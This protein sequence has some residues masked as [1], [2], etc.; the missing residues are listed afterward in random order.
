MVALTDFVEVDEVG[1]GLLGPNPRRLIELSREDAHGSRNRD[2]LDVAHE[3][4]LSPD[5][6]GFGLVT[7]QR[8]IVSSARRACR[9]LTVKPTPQGSRHK[10]RQTMGPLKGCSGLVPLIAMLRHHA[11]VDHQGPMR[12]VYSARTQ[13]ELRYRDELSSIDDGAEPSPSPSSG[14]RHPA[15]WADPGG[16][17]PTSS[18]RHGG[19]PS[20]APRCYVCGPTSFVETVADALIALGHRVADIRTGGRHDRRAGRERCRG[21]AR[22]HLPPGDDRRPCNLRDLRR[23]APDRGAA[24]LPPRS[25]LQPTSTETTSA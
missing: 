16:S 18:P 13:A 12:L 9:P 24:R 15:G 17:T 2:A 11:A 10:R 14:S 20:A 6:T 3:D 19:P 8:L 25:A 23:L 1:V 4:P 22:G 5:L 21:S 7:A